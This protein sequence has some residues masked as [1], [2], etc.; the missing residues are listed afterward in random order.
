MTH[1][2]YLIHSAAPSGAELAL[3]R[4]IS[5]WP[6]SDQIDLLVASNG[7]MIEVFSA[8][9]A[10]VTVQEFPEALRAVRRGSG[11]LAKFRA[12]GQ[13]ALYV[14]DVRSL[15]RH[16]GPDVVVAGSLRSVLYGRL[17]T[18]GL[19]L[20]FVWSLHDQITRDY[21]GRASAL[22]RYVLP[23]FVQGIIANS[24]STL[25]TVRRGRT[26][27]AICPPG[28]RVAP[29]PD[30]VADGPVSDFVMVGRLSEWKGQHVA[31]EAFS[32]A[33]IPGAK[34]HI[35]GGALFGEDQYVAR[36]HR[37]CDDLKVADSVIWHGHV[38]DAS[39]MLKEF[40]SL[41]HA[42]VLPEPFGAVVI[43]GMNA[44]CVVIASD[45]GG[46]AEVIHHGIDGFLAA[47]GDAES[48]ANAMRRVH[49]LDRSEREAIAI[50]ANQTAQQYSINRVTNKRAT[51]IREI[52][53]GGGVG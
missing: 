26:P 39:A 23:R 41:I 7:P 6:K 24:S 48:L 25:R 44:G 14:R 1:I 16:L 15:I 19:G 2:A 27:A 35:V 13:M 8:A 22:Y 49:Q 21:V 34:L 43:E 51:F 18:A 4:A 28:I 17:A 29:L 37:L 45:A 50:A 30:Q 52:S 9:G 47:Q 12:L 20:P 3:G 46:P 11:L 33:G 53:R 31:I 32:R 36:L 40:P 10:R 38:D 5:V 42:S